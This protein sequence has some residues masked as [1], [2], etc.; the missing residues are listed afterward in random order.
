MTAEAVAAEHR[1]RL[2]EAALEVVAEHGYGGATVQQLAAAASV[3]TATLYEQFAGREELVLSAIDDALAHA[4]ERVRAKEL[5]RDDVH[6]A[7]AAALAAIVE[8]VTAQP[9]AARAAIVESPAIG[10]AGQERRRALV[11]AVHDH[12]RRAAT[13]DGRPA[14]SEGALVVLAGGAVEVIGDELRAGRLRTLRSAAAD[15]AAW[16]AMYE[17]ARPRR[18]PAPPMQRPA[19]PT[20]PPPPATTSLPGGR[21]G[22]PA[23]FVRR[24]QR[25]RI[26]EAVR[27]IA[28][29][30]GFEATGVRDLVRCA[31][32]S[33]EAFYRHFGSKEEAWAAAFDAAFSGLFAA[34]WHAASAESRRADKVGAAVLAG[35][36]FLQSDP[37]AARLLLVDAPTA[38][39]AGAPALDEAR[40]ALTRQLARA[41]ALEQ[42][43]TIALGLTGGLTELAASWVLDGRTAELPELAAAVIEIILTPSLGLEEASRTADQAV[44]P[45]PPAATS[46]D[47]R[48]MLTAF[49]RAVA[50][51]G[52]E[53]THLDDV[54]RD[55]GVDLDV[56]HDLFRDDLNCATQCLDW[57]AGRL[58]TI[59]AG[60]F[61]AAADDPPLAAHRALE[62]AVDHIVRTP[63]FAS[64]VVSDHPDLAVV[65][66]DLRRRYLGLFFQLVSGQVGAREQQAD[67][68]LP[69][70]EVVLNGLWAVLR[71][72]AQEERIHELPGELPALSRQCLTPF[73][74]PD[75][76]ARV[77]AQVGAPS[78]T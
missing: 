31:G 54:A 7:L 6:A 71:R 34:M 75:E 20:M 52:F 62:A 45:P 76:A 67:E 35:L 51:D 18:L 39:R 32:L 48:R 38:G 23:S 63:D 33:M 41:A 4:R 58:V 3:S 12:L 70:L 9:A 50:R 46:D 21:H 65:A 1:A 66:L 74:G 69:A 19:E 17:S 44:T 64:L 15:L 43:R 68:P 5:P 59:A 16:G 29:D 25:E 8:A 40:R 55:A 73:F 47:R 27:F 36:R 61:L 11:R 24:H 28:A 22:L 49:A 2:Q 13:V 30:R 37:A 77:A 53:A 72:F 60:A 10:P 14:I 78:G 56:A 26:M 57:W 42:R